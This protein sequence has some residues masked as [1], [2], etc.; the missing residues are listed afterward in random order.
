MTPFYTHIAGVPGFGIHATADKV[1][2]W[3]AAGVAAAYA[4]GGLVQYGRRL[5][6]ARSEAAAV[7][8]E[9]GGQS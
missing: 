4:I 6:H 3:A 5:A 1:G 9:K 8:E 2:L 7:E